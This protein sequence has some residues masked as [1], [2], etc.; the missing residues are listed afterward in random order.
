VRYHLDVGEGPGAVHHLVEMRNDAARAETI[1]AVERVVDAVED[2]NVEP[3][4]PDCGLNV[5]G[6]TPY[7]ETPTDVAAVEGK[8]SRT[9]SGVR[10]NR[11]VRFETAGQTAEVL[12]GVREVEPALRFAARCRFEEDVADA[13]DVLG[14][15]VVEVDRSD[16]EQSGLRAA[17][18]RAL[19]DEQGIAVAVADPGAVGTE[20]SVFLLGRDESTLIDRV[21][22]L[23]D[24]L[25]TA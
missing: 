10:S 13:L 4:V 1:E 18:R 9:R 15:S 3:L 22:A 6:A 19:D 25:G 12:L 24:A 7:A 11:G 17:T 2:R 16:S 14:G 20:A 23:L 5:A 21:V 8:I